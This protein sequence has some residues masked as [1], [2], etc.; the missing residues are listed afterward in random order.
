M[1]MDGLEQRSSSCRLAMVEFGFEPKREQRL[2]PSE[3]VLAL[4]EGRFVWIDVFSSERTQTLLG[5]LHSNELH[6]PRGYAFFGALVAT[7][8]RSYCWA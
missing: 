3:L 1:S 4:A 7:I 8:V 2:E 5:N 6:W